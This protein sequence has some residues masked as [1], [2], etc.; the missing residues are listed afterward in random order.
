METVATDLEARLGISQKLRMMTEQAASRRPAP[1]KWS[2]KETL[3]HLIDSA[4]N[5]HQRFVR[6][7]MQK[8]LELVGYDG[9]EW[10]KLERYGE[11]PWLDVVNL[12]ET[13]NRHLAHVIRHVDPSA[14]KHT[15]R[16]PEGEI[17]DLEFV[18]RDYVTHM[19]HHLDQITV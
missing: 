18:I 19:Q 11:R 3:G 1:E 7:Q 13:Y 16:S 6:M 15:W 12:W 10:V 4:A 8:H 9:D 2:A 17:V 5:N 14:L